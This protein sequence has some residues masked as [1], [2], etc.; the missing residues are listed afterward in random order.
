MKWAE[1][2]QTGTHI[3]KIRK[4]TTRA[5]G[6]FFERGGEKIGLKHRK[7]EAVQRSC[8]EKVLERDHMKEKVTWT[9]Q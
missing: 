9:K 2:R 3:R 1:V 7:R 8:R 4:I 6:S 5:V